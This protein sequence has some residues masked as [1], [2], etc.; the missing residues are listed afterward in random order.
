[1]AS[2]STTAGSIVIARERQRKALELRKAGCTYEQIAR[3][4]GYRAISAAEKAV[5]VALARLTR[6]PAE[7]LRNLELQRLDSLFLTF[8]QQAKGGN[9]GALDRILRIMERRAKL[10]GLDAPIEQN[11]N[12]PNVYRFPIKIGDQSEW[13][14]LAKGHAKSN[15]IE[16]GN[17]NEDGAA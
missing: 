9:Q 12:L 16:G 15:G 4:I 3:Q 2:R 7:E 17:S 10:L 6:E 11:I 1:M 13:E 5:K 14:K 8:W